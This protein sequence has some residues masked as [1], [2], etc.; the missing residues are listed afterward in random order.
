MEKVVEAAFTVWLILITIRYGLSVLR[1]IAAPFNPGSDIE[2][3]AL[4]LVAAGVIA[5]CLA[6]W[7]DILRVVLVGGPAG[8]CHDICRQRRFPCS[9]SRVMA[10]RCCVRLGSMV[11]ACGWC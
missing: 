7:S 6:A 1:G 11:V 9:S 5:I 8:H 3:F 2:W 10:G 4:W